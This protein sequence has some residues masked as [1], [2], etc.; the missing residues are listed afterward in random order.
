MF[1]SMALREYYGGEKSKGIIGWLEVIE[2][3]LS[4]TLAETTATERSA[5]MMERQAPKMQKCR[6]LGRSTPIQRPLMSS[7]AWDFVL[8]M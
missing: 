5:V 3:D 4:T 8:R 1:I 7:C 2:F 6:K